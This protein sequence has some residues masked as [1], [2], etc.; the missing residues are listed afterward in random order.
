[1]II[2]IIII[3]IVVII[4]MIIV[5]I[6]MIIIIII[7]IIMIILLQFLPWSI[8][9]AVIYF[10]ASPKTGLHFQKLPS[11]IKWIRFLFWYWKLD[12]YFDVTLFVTL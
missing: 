12:S 10:K 5:T 8:S 4:L 9:A 2:I 7:I 1:M 3:I 11:V 6:I